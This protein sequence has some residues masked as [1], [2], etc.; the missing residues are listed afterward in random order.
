MGMRQVTPNIRPPQGIMQKNPI[1]MN[2]MNMNMAQNMNQNQMQMNQQMGMAQMQP[3]NANMAQMNQMNM[4]QQGMAQMNKNQMAPNQTPQQRQQF[5]MNVGNNMMPTANSALI[6]QLNQPS[7]LPM[8]GPPQQQQQQQPQQPGMMRMPMVNQQPAAMMQN[9]AQ[10][11]NMSMQNPNM[12]G[13][14]GMINQQTQQQQQQQQQSAQMNPIQQNPAQQQPQGQQMGNVPQRDR[15]W[16]GILEWN[17]KQNQQNQVRQVPCE[18]YASISKETN[19]VEIRGDSWPNRLIMQLMP[20][21]VISNVG[22]QLLRDAKVVQFSWGNSEA[23]ES[24][25]KV[26]SNGFAGCVHFTGHQQCDVKILILL[27]M[28]DKKSYYGGCCHPGHPTPRI[29]TKNCRKSSKM[30]GVG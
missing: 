2:Q 3:N 7:T 4:N 28:P 24:L 19:E 15:I 11:P 23:F 20:R 29:P 14:V 6:N 18:I 9:Q 5:I 25:S 26:M 21:S 17:D 30:P 12:M 13:Q 8:T 22:G 16:R 27:Y 1:M 10:N